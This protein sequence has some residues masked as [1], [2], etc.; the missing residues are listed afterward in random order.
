[1]LII[2]ETHLDDSRDESPFKH[3]KYHIFRRD[4]RNKDD[5]IKNDVPY[6]VLI[7]YISK[8]YDKPLSLVDVSDKIEAI[9]FTIKFEK[10]KII[11]FIIAYRPPEKDTDPNNHVFFLRK[12]PKKSKSLKK[13]VMTFS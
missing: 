5:N 2:Q 6:G 10:R 4:R 9:N 13:Q 7:V 1:M 3:Q 12:S 8:G 11:S